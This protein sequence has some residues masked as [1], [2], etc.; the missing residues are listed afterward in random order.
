MGYGHRL[1]EGL[2]TSGENSG[3]WS[4]DP[5]ESDEEDVQDVGWKRNIVEEQRVQVEEVKLTARQERRL[6]GEHQRAVHAARQEEGLRAERAQEEEARREAA[7]E[8]QWWKNRGVP[9]G[10]IGGV[11]A[12]AGM[13]NVLGWERQE[14]VL[15][16]LFVAVA[17][18]KV[19]G[20]E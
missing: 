2:S 1:W 16:I 17:V 9:A 8:W 3:S 18:G 4:S 13:V 5:P 11:V 7:Q 20:R 12:V 15:V 19:L 6:E 14:A 10:L